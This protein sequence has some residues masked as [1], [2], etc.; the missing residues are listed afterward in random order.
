MKK[1]FIISVVFSIAVLLCC[2]PVVTGSADENPAP[3]LKV[4]ISINEDSLKTDF[5]KE[6]NRFYIDAI[7]KNISNKDQDIIV[8]TQAG[9]S[10]TSNNQEISPGKEARK[11]FPTKI[12]LNSNQEYRQG[13]EIWSDPHK[14]IPVTFRLGFFP[15]AEL[16]IPKWTDIDASKGIIWS[17]PVALT[18]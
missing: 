2:S 11:N 7:I 6:T 5:Y 4:E 3:S 9:W 1:I 12:T 18:Q 15:N 10:W 14:K 13:I 17:N 16:P 8:W